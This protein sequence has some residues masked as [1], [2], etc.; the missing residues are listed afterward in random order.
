MTQRSLGISFAA[1]LM[2]TSITSCSSTLTLP[3]SLFGSWSKDGGTVAELSL[4][5]G[6]RIEMVLH[7]GT[8]CAGSYGLSAMS[9]DEAIISTGYIQCPGLMDGYEM[10]G[11]ISI[12]GDTLTVHGVFGGTYTR[13]G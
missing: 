2:L 5:D 3:Q 1:I 13:S 12:N 9:D 6:G 4:S 10:G 8:E 7:D 11:D